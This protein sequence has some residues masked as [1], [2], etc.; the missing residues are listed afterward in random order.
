MCDSSSRKNYNL[1]IRPL[2]YTYDKGYNST[3]AA[4]AAKSSANMIS[5]ASFTKKIIKFIYVSTYVSNKN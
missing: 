1:T 2:I 3:K 5:F 4:L